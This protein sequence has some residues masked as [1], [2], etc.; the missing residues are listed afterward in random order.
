M[1]GA[2]DTLRSRL[3]MFRAARGYSQLR[4]EQRAKLA[5]GQYWRIENGYD[6]PTDRELRRIAKALGISTDDLIPTTNNA[7]QIAVAV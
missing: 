6:T 4:T 1:S 5:R 3:R 2:R 7:D